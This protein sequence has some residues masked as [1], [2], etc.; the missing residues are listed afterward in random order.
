MSTVY[1]PVSSWRLG[2]SLGIDVVLPPKK[3][4]FNC[5]YCQL[6]K[7][8]VHVSNPEVLQGKL[9]DAETVRRDL[10]DVLKRL[11]ISTVDVVTFSGSGE[12]T[13]NLELGK[14]AGMVKERI[15]AVPLAVL[16]NSS[17]F[18][19]EKVRENLASFDIV[20]AKLDAGDNTTFHAINRPV[21]AALNIK[22][23][24]SSIEK[25][26][27]TVKSPLALEVMLLRSADDRITNV[28]GK[29]LQA[30]LDAII[31]VNPDQVQLGVPYRPPSESFVE[32]PSQEEVE[33]VFEGLAKHF[34]K[35]KLRVYGSYDEHGKG[36]R[37]LFHKSLERE[38]IELL[39]RRPCSVVD[40]SKS[41]GISLLTATSLLKRLV[42]ENLVTV[43]VR[44]GKKYYL[45]REDLRSS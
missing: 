6:G 32:I 22:T 17:L 44:K 2:R 34:E 31:N 27:H 20:V 26:K 4:T 35:S 43:E 18:Y 7:T 14:I 39:E 5:V 33:L 30:L 10:D 21:D 36:V 3:C 1:G 19:K 41:L 25:V 13:L 45:K 29:P 16:T 38:A 23:V 12:P 9:V 37:W 42:S 8:S 15:G 24:I 11:D 28:E 40:V